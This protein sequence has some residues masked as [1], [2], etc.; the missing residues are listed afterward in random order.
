MGA[1]GE[2]CND[3]PRRLERNGLAANA[4]QAA[5]LLSHST[6]YPIPD[7]MSQPKLYAPNSFICSSFFTLIIISEHYVPLLMLT[8]FKV[9]AFA[10]TGDLVVHGTGN[11]HISF[12]AGYPGI[13]PG[14][15]DRP[16]A[17]VKGVCLIRAV[18]PRIYS[19]PSFLIGH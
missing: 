4:I 17:A 14:G 13:P 8:S 2:Q 5:R 9:R 10:A 11:A 19:R 3:V 7:S 16:Q 12:H 6:T 18:Y 1:C 15:P